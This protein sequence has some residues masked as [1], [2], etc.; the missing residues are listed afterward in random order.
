MRGIW[1][2]VL[3]RRPRMPFW[4]LMWAS[5]GKVTGTPCRSTRVSFVVAKAAVCG[6]PTICVQILRKEL[7]LQM[8]SAISLS[9]TPSLATS[10]HAWLPRCILIYSFT[11]CACLS[12]S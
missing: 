6:G 8:R 4:C 3:G 2:K 12:C 10:G 1:R 11:L 9:F 5:T 7:F